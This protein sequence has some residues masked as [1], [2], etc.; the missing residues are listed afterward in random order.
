MNYL[1][2]LK[3]EQLHEDGLEVKNPFNNHSICKVATFSAD[4]IDELVEDANK[5]MQAWKRTSAKHRAQTLRKWFDLIMENQELLAQLMTA[6]CGKPISESRGEVAYGAS[7]V[8]W[9]AEEI[10]RSNGDIVPSHAADKQ[11]L[12]LKQAIGVCAAI[13]PWNFPLAMI[14]RKV[15]PAL[16]AGCAIL[17]KP[18]EAT[19][20]TA[21]AIENLAKQAG[22]PDALFKVLPSNNP[23]AIGEQFCQHN[24]IRKLSFTGSTQVGRMLMQQSAANIKKLSL[25]LGGNAPFIIFADA[26]IDAAV[27]GAMASKFRNAGQTCICANRF[28]VHQDVMA[29]FVAKLTTK[30]KQL[31]IGDGA[32]ETTKIGPLINEAAIRKVQ[33]LV[34]TAVD[35]GATL[36]CGGK[37]SKTNERIFLPTVLS[38]VTPDMKIMFE[39]IFGPVVTI[40]E[41]NSTQEAIDIAN[42][43]IFGLAAYFYTQSQKTTWQVMQALEY[44]MVGINEGI[45]STEV[46]PFGG[47]KQSGLGREGSKYGLDEYLELKYALLGGLD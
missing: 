16:A 43:T 20:L 46:A 28:I 12:V 29:T 39:E 35:E 26:D 8:E 44:G 25:E 40:C 14:T 32:S 30:I 19:P 3:T 41:F 11:V 17:V 1:Q 33:D 31:E 2:L 45:I 13:T 6:E 37:V 4:T 10:K 27:E 42:N 21:L 23:K 36:V 22:I 18:A 15:A 9:F 34:T 7:F 47:I 38:N 24:T 5:S